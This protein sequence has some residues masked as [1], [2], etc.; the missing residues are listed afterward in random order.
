MQKRGVGRVGAAFL[1]QKSTASTKTV[2]AVLSLEYEILVL[3]R[4]RE[5]D[6]VVL[7]VLVGLLVLGCELNDF[8]VSDTSA[9][10]VENLCEKTVGF[11]LVA[12]CGDS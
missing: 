9:V 11:K 7:F 5:G 12:Y 2:P 6:S 1:R 10:H 3:F 8:K 4:G